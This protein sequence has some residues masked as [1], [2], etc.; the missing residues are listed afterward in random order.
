MKYPRTSTIRDIR[1]QNNEV[2]QIKLLSLK[3]TVLFVET[4]RFLLLISCTGAITVFMFYSTIQKQILK[5]FRV[6][7]NEAREV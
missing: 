5:T 4:Q 2:Q 6:R 7:N 3:R 1:D